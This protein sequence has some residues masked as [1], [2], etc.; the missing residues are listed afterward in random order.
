MAI[1]VHSPGCAAP[2]PDFHSPVIAVGRNC[3]RI[4][5]R[6]RDHHSAQHSNQKR[7]SSSHVQYS[8]ICDCFTAIARLADFLLPLKSCPVLCLSGSTLFGTLLFYPSFATRRQPGP[9]QPR[10]ERTPMFTEI[11][12]RS[13]ICD[14]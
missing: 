1:F 4:R 12:R 9:F 3:E 11:G 14:T 5:D 7:A 8:P 10:I 2:F 13:F 6:G